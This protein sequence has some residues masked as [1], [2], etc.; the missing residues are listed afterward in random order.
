LGLAS[1]R[2]WAALVVLG[3]VRLFAHADG[4]EPTLAYAGP[5][6]LVGT[7]LVRAHDATPIDLQAVAPSVVMLLPPNRIRDL[8]RAE[9]PFAN[10]VVDHAQTFVGSTVATLAAR[11]G[12]DLSQRLAREITLLAELFPAQGLIPVT[13]QQLADGVGSIRESVARTLGDFRRDGWVATT[14]HG[15]LVLDGG[16]VRRAAGPNA[17][18]ESALVLGRGSEGAVT[19]PEDGGT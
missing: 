14:R 7:H 19:N 10:A 2:A 5:G 1:H 13:E 18:Y 16:A 4:M 6:A 11:T 12:A 8:I 17:V 9:A 15:L 3:I